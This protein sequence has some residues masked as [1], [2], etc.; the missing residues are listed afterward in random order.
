MREHTPRHDPHSRFED[1]GIPDLQDGTPQ[2]QWAVDPQ[3]A[4]LPADRPVAMDDFGTT[5]DEQIQGESLEGRLSREI[6]EEQPVFGA[7]ADGT[8]GPATGSDAGAGEERDLDPEIPGGLDPRVDA[9]SGLGVG[10][11]L[12]TD[13]QPDDDVDADWSA[14]PEEPS[15][16]VWDEPRRAGRLVDP[17]EGARPDTEADLVAEEVGPDAGGYTAEEAAMRVEPE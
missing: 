16:A 6:P 5:V 4:P 3:E 17:D 10:S 13:Y 1:E 14:Q 2:Q 8:A 12:D 7:D 15:G 11:D 9:E